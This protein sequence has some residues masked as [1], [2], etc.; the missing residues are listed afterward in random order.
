[1]DFVRFPATVSG[2]I[3]E[4]II[5]C[6]DYTARKISERELRSFIHAL[7]N[8]SADKLFNGPNSFN[9]TITQRLGKKRL[10]LV[11]AMLEG[12]QQRFM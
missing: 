5:A 3:K 9:P 1:M 2:L 12:Y 6:D 10:R 11:E 7:A 4:L 8:S